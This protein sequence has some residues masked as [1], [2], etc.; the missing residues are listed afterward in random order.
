[1]KVAII[2]VLFPCPSETFVLSQ[3][4]GAL[5]RGVDARIFARD[6]A[7]NFELSE[8]SEKYHL[9][10]RTTY[11]GKGLDIASCPKVS[12]IFTALKIYLKS[13]KS[14]RR[15]L[16]KSLNYKK[17]GKKAF[18][19][20][21]FYMAY[22]FSNIGLEDFDV[23]H[24]QFG[25]IGQIAAVLK[26]VGIIQGSIITS[27]HGYDLS[28]YLD[29]VSDNPY[30]RLFRCGELFLP[31]SLFWK[32]KLIKLGCPE[33]KI[34]VHRMGV[35]ID[36]FRFQPRA[37]KEGNFIVRIISVGRMV[38]KK[39]FEYGI[40]AF[41]RLYPSHPNLRYLVVGDGELMKYLKSL[42]KNLGV[43]KAVSFIGWKEPKEII[44]LMSGSD[45][46]IAPCVTASNGDQEGIPMV[47]MEAMALGL[48]VISTYHT[49]IPELIENGI[50]GYLVP[51]RDV[52][53]LSNRLEDLIQNNHIWDKLAIAGRTKVEKEYN[54][55]IQNDL[56]VDLYTRNQSEK[57]L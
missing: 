29:K 30:T 23:V 45:I 47:I 13:S 51:E 11:Y 27:F 32:Q 57:H 43:N 44:N 28:V 1:M 54:S 38:E 31:I 50:S 24:C 5:D 7:A 6:K 16:L 48:P 3:I 37:Q 12:R 19:L 20:Q 17:F 46:Y 33:D 10:K 22:S 49:G 8:S 41:A 55:K 14:T 21:C 9:K 4:K 52:D 53:L 56:L 36:K 2:T 26:E 25:T 39:G 18:S 42:A 40:R 15:T 34:I 35:E